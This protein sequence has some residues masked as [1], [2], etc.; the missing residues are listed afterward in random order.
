MQA[1]LNCLNALFIGYEATFKTAICPID[2]K[3][4]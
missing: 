1:I 3:N 2:R 4:A